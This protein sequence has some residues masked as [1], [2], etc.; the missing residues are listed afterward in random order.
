MGEIADI[1]KA[2]EK[3]AIEKNWKKYHTIRNLVLAL[4]SEVGE[5]QAEF[6]WL[7]EE[8]TIN[9][10]LDKLNSIKDEIADVAIFLFRISDLLKI[11]LNTAIH[12]KIAINESRIQDGPN[13]KKQN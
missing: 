9:L 6:R 5:L 2:L 7:T 10:S 8:E 12:E 13:F 3:F 1:Q 11:D 4:G